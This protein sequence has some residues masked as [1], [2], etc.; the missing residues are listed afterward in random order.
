MHDLVLLVSIRALFQGIAHLVSPPLPFF[1][2]RESR[3]VLEYIAHK[4]IGRPQWFE[5]YVPFIFELAWFVNEIS[6]SASPTAVIKVLIF[7]IDVAAGSFWYFI[8]KRL[9]TAGLNKNKHVKGYDFVSQ[10]LFIAGLHMLNP[11]SILYNETCNCDSVRYFWVSLAVFS[12]LQLYGYRPGG[13]PS[14]VLYQ[15][16]TCGMLLNGSFKMLAVLL[17]LTYLVVHK[18]LRLS[19]STSL[20]WSEWKFMMRSIVPHILVT[21]SMYV[22]YYVLVDHHMIRQ[23]LDIDYGGRG[24]GIDFSLY[25]YLNR[26]LHSPFNIVNIFKAHMIIFVFPLPLLVVLRHRPMEYLITM[27]SISILQQP[28]LSLVGLWFMICLFAVHYPLMDKSL[29]FTKMMMILFATV[30]LSVVA[31]IAWVGR[32]I[33]NPNYFFAPQLLILILMCMVLEDYTKVNFNLMSTSK[34]Q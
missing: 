12:A 1:V 27:L 9:S 17:P 26:V 4:S 8:V 10:P 20:S 29:A 24:S 28:R 2:T 33:A 19:N 16:A 15:F 18:R 31:Y 32:Y 21:I 11:L 22:L 14:Y 23:I 6:V 34:S 3:D 7:L 30:I 13:I 25:W 5:G